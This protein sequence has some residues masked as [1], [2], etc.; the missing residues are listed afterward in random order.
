LQKKAQ[1]IGPTPRFAKLIGDGVII[2]TPIGSTGYNRSASGPVLLPKSPLLALTGPAI[3]EKS[4]WFNTVVPHDADIDIEILDPT[5]RPVRLETSQEEIAEISRVR[6]S[7]SSEHELML[8][9]DAL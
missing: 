4:D 1:F 9:Q 8:L 3:H 2:T 5:Y 6:I 7:S